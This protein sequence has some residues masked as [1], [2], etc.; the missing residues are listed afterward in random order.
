M[1]GGRA[2]GIPH[3]IEDGGNGF[4]VETVTQAAER[5]IQLVR[6]PELRRRLGARARETVRARFPDDPANGRLARPH[7]LLR[8]QLSAQRHPQRMKTRPPTRL[9]TLLE[10]CGGRSHAV[11]RLSTDALLPE[12]VP[13][14]P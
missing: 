14:V 6:D 8:G 1:I 12:P 5:I 11:T 4:L 7:R 2:G 3:Q 9:R 13:P 10:V